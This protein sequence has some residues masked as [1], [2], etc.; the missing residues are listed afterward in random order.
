MTDAIIVGAGL[1]GATIARAL[2]NVGLTTM[3]F[4]AR[5][6]L[7][8]SP[9]S[10]SLMK[11]SWFDGLGKDVYN[12]ALAMLGSLYR[13]QELD[14]TVAP[15]LF[16]TKVLWVPT[17]EIVEL[18]GVVEEEVLDVR[19]G[20]VRTAGAV[21][22]WVEHEARIVI[23]AA[24]YWSRKLVPSMPEI[25]GK[26]GV[27]FRHAGSEL[28][29]GNT[30]NPWAPYKQMVKF[31]EG[32]RG[33]WA[34]DGT[35]IKADNWTDERMGQSHARIQKFVGREGLVPYVGIRPYVPGKKPAYCE[36]VS[37]QGEPEVWVA[38]GGAKNG[39]IAAGWAAKRIVDAVAR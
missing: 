28:P 12:P 37:A 10:G 26:Q 18:D 35:A 20:L 24:G 14:F 34:G 22:G 25:E 31:V 5:R 27:A 6:P 4:D 17:T 29:G 23:V 32:D 39:L 8:A 36:R 3:V 38:T 7:A 21:T 1:F 9:A 16:K 19:P 13:L 11:P 30:I 33:L 15:K 2:R